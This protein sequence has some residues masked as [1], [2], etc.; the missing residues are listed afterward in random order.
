MLFHTTAKW[1]TADVE[2]SR[3]TDFEYYYL[4]TNRNWSPVKLPKKDL[5]RG[6]TSSVFSIG[7]QAVKLY[8]RTLSTEKR[9]ALMRKIVKMAFKH[10]ELAILEDRPLAWPLGPLVCRSVAP[11]S[12]DLDCSEFCGYVMPLVPN[13]FVVDDVIS[14]RKLGSKEITGRDRVF[15]AKRIAEI[16]AICHDKGFLIGDLNTRNIVISRDTLIPTIIDCDSFQYGN[17]SSDVGTIEFSS[18]CL[19]QRLLNNGGRFEGVM[20]NAADDNHALAVLIFMMLMNGRHPYDHAR[21]EPL[22]TSIPK[23]SFPY[24]PVPHANAPLESDLKRYAILDADLRSLFERALLLGE[25]VEPKTWIT[26][27]D[28]FSRKPECELIVPPRI[29][30]REPAD[31][32]QR[33]PSWAKIARIVLFLILIIIVIVVVFLLSVRD[34]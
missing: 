22:L 23:R 25:V 20:R 14:D 29:T 11:T 3:M 32:D 24:G 17:D 27:L 13:P 10:Q 28:Q 7:H 26:S 4:D 18:P 15:I 6:R 5:G 9:S 30:L 8:D 31:P 19:L 1:E 12:T 21:M 16:M 34:N 2:F 33:E